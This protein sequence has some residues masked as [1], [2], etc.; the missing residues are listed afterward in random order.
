MALLIFSSPIGWVGRGSV[1]KGLFTFVPK[2]RSSVEVGE[3]D[4]QSRILSVSVSF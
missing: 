4:G 1:V 3:C 2:C